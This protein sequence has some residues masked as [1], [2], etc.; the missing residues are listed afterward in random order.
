[1]PNYLRRRDLNN[2]NEGINDN[3][4][5]LL[6]LISYAIII[7]KYNKNNNYKIINEFLHLIHTILIISLLTYNINNIAI[8]T[9]LAFYIIDTIKLICIDK[10][11]KYQFILHHIIAI[12]SLYNTYF[13]VENIKNN[14]LEIF[15]ILEYSNIMLYINNIIYNL[16][17]NK[18]IITFISIKQFLWYSICR[19]IFFGICIYNN[20]DTILQKQIYIKIT[21]FSI[22]LI[23]FIWSIFLAKRTWNYIKL[24][25]KIHHIYNINYKLE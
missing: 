6:S 13:D 2:P 25:Y 1:M 14:A 12:Y 15:Y 8:I 23:G 20:F 3:Q 4:I 19:I 18:Y 10:I 7:F 5:F 9:S 16:T 21:I 11:K 24:N 17:K 22:Y